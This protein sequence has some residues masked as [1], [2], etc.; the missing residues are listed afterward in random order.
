MER[1]KDQL[2]LLLLLYLLLR[3]QR[4]AM[5]R[6]DVIRTRDTHTPHKPYAAITSWQHTLPAH[7]L[8]W[9]QQHAGN[10]SPSLDR[11]TLT[12]V[13]VGAE[14]ALPKPVAA[15]AA[16]EDDAPKLSGPFPFILAVCH[17]FGDCCPRMMQERCV[18][19]P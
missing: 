19:L 13:S 3:M 10:R 1:T 15:D 2:L 14:L 12:P 11:V 5:I 7:L 18:P 4:V 6:S 8:L 9:G 16:D 17:L